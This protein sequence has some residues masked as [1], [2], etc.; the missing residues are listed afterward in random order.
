MRNRK[1]ASRKPCQTRYSDQSTAW[2][3]IG[4]RQDRERARERTNFAAFNP[5]S[6]PVTFA[7]EL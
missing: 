7:V 4:L 5:G 1:P 3:F 2:H 6:D